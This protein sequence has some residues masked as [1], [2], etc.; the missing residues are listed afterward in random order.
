MP[1]GEVAPEDVVVRGGLACLGFLETSSAEY[2]FKRSMSYVPRR[3]K[4]RLRQDVVY[5]K[6]ENEE[7]RSRSSV[8]E[9]VSQTS[10]STGG[11]KH[12]DTN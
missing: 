4:N 10:A 11:G 1:M 3:C 8:K 5:E 2:L 6:D 12:E 9:R 7:C